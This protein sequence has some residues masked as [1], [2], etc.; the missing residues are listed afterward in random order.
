MTYNFD[1][2]AWLDRERTLLE[3][4]RDD[5]EIDAE[6]FDRALEELEERHRRM[7]EG[8]DGTFRIPD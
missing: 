7:W 8:L 5:G 1:P 2:D 3:K 6:E 4:K